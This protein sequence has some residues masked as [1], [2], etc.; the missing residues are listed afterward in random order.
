MLHL[1]PT[2]SKMV[3]NKYFIVPFIKRKT[4]PLFINACAAIFNNTVLLENFKNISLRDTTKH[5][6]TV[7]GTGVDEDYIVDNLNRNQFLICLMNHDDY[8][9][10]GFVYGKVN[11]PHKYTWSAFY[12]N[13]LCAHNNLKAIGFTLVNILKLLSIEINKN[14]PSKIG[15]TLDSVDS[16]NTIDFYNKQDIL[17]LSSKSNLLRGWKLDPSINIERSLI[18]KITRIEVKK[19]A[20]SGSFDFKSQS[21]EE[22]PPTPREDFMERLTRQLFKHQK[23]ETPTKDFVLIN[24]PRLKGIN[25]KITKK[26]RKIDKQTREIQRQLDESN[27][28]MNSSEHMSFDT[29]VRQPDLWYLDE[30]RVSPTELNLLKKK[31]ERK[32]K[33]LKKH[34]PRFHDSNNYFNVLR[35][36]SSP[37]LG[38]DKS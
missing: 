9:L 12:I 21:S 20:N 3:K 11:D 25:K 14:D 37:S 17:P 4:E 6:C 34:R 28:Y 31:K 5:L 16:P 29:F 23:K 19:R 1:Q 38:S 33:R 27:A 36:S 15:F 24:H 18:Q 7:K 32:T 10:A 30:G 22:T 8:S 2:Q 13:V 26:Q 35:Q